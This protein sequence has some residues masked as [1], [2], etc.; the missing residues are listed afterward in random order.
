MVASAGPGLLA[1][2]RDAPLSTPD[3]LQSSSRHC[4]F[5]LD[6][7]TTPLYLI[8]FDYRPF[9]HEAFGTWEIPCPKDVARSVPKRRAEFFFGRFA[10]RLAMTELVAGRTAQWA[11]STV[12]AAAGV[13][14]GAVHSDV[15]PRVVDAEI[16]VGAGGQ[17]V[18]PQGLIG[19]ISHATSFAAALV[20]TRGPRQGVGIDLEHV[21]GPDDCLALVGVVINETELKYLHALT[22]AWPLE[23]LLTIVFS[24]KESLFKGAYGAVGRYFDFNV[25]QLEELDLARG[26]VRFRLTETLSP[27][28]LRSQC[29]TVGFEFLRSNLLLTHFAW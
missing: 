29:C 10:A 4:L 22:E 23:L 13:R 8:E 21:I 19:T 1:L 3:A 18:W 16:P 24:A 27:Q 20:D 14:G 25:A 28:F 15:L 5:G 12:P 26:H 9:S 17:P 6:G 7:R 2:S 11:T